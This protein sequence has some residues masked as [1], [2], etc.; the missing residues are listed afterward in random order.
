M[1]SSN[2]SNVEKAGDPCSLTTEQ[3]FNVFHSSAVGDCI[4]FL[5]KKGDI[6]GEWQNASATRK[7]DHFAVVFESDPATI[8]QY[9]FEDEQHSL[10][11][12]NLWELGWYK[13]PESIMAVGSGSKESDI[14]EIPR[15]EDPSKFTITEFKGKSFDGV[16]RVGGKA[17]FFE[18][19]VCSN[20]TFSPKDSVICN[21]KRGIFFFAV[22]PEDGSEAQAVVFTFEPDI[23]AFV[24]LSNV[25]KQSAEVNDQPDQESFNIMKTTVRE[26]IRKQ[27]KSPNVGKSSEQAKPSAKAVVQEVLEVEGEVSSDDHDDFEDFDNSTTPKD[28]RHSTRSL[29]KSQPTKKFSPQQQL[30]SK[31]KRTEGGAYTSRKKT[32]RGKL[33][34]N[35]E[36]KGKQSNPPGAPE[37]V[38]TKRSVVPTPVQ[39]LGSASIQQHCQG[40]T[41]TIDNVVNAIGVM[42]KDIQDLKR[43]SDAEQLQPIMHPPVVSSLPLQSGMQIGLPPLPMQQPGT[44]S[45]GSEVLQAV[46][47]MAAMMYMNS[48]NN[49][50]R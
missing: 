11:S 23:P 6:G 42:Q 22:Q 19:V 10:L 20:G 7:A 31:R 1:S 21:S 16:L 2:P 33:N 25:V 41:N 12:K 15:G 5:A 17:K 36:L 4:Q 9:F 50:F 30:N 26:Y 13:L 46:K 40:I 34:L 43:A 45:G 38:S 14:T 27:I 44:V 37:Q 39:N 48:V 18:T 24:Q 47:F 35:K 29:R 49:F 8:C 28:K 32:A 3:S